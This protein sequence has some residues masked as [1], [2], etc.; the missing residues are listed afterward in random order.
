MRME[1]EVK[2]ETSEQQAAPQAPEAAAT[3]ALA[4]G[5]A[6]AEPGSIAPRSNPNMRWYIIHS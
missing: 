5:G 1:E 2:N 3:E 6:A 4:E